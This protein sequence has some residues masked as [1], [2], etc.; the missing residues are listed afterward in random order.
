MAVENRVLNI[1]KQFVDSCREDIPEEADFVKDLG[2]DS[3]G[4]TELCMSL[5]DSFDLDLDFDINSFPV[6][7]VQ[8]AINLVKVNS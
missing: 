4:M 1:V 5:E 8:D 3:L 2:L 6:A 7:S